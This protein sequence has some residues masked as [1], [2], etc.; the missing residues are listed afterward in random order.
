MFIPQNVWYLMG[1][2]IRYWECSDGKYSPCFQGTHKKSTF[3]YMHIKACS[4]RDDLYM[5]EWKHLREKESLLLVGCEGLG[6]AF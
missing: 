4:G 5:V 1:I 6:M 3:K 2:F